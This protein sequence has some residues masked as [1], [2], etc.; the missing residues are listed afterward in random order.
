MKE[1][2]TFE[3]WYKFNVVDN[4][5]IDE[6]TDFC[7]K[8]FTSPAMSKSN[9]VMEILTPARIAFKLFAELTL[10]S[11]FPKYDNFRNASICVCLYLDHNDRKRGDDY[12]LFE[13]NI[14]SK[15]D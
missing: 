6:N 5:I 13:D 8:V 3:E 14:N 15:E 11:I 1:R 12:E 2:I 9:M 7:V 10:L 4:E